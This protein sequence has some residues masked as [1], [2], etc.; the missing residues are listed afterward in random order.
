MGTAALIAQERGPEGNLKAPD[1]C[2]QVLF[3]APLGTQRRGVQMPVLTSERLPSVRRL[4]ASG[5]LGPSL[6]FIAQGGT[7][8]RSGVWRTERMMAVVIVLFSTR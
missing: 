5:W 8:T 2:P 3:I 4:G 1:A 7:P 6:R